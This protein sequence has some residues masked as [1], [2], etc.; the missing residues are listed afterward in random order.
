M[1]EILVAL[2]DS[3]DGRLHSTNILGHHSMFFQVFTILL[4]LPPLDEFDETRSLL[5]LLSQG[6]VNH[7]LVL[8]LQGLQFC[9]KFFQFLSLLL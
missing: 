8:A 1:Q 6:F 7:V 4:F 9:L 2:L 3:F 5:L